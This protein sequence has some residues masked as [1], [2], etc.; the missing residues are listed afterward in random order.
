MKKALTL[1]LIVFICSTTS[2]EKNQFVERVSSFWVKNNSSGNIS[3]SYS[4]LYPDT[5]IAHIPRYKVTRVSSSEQVPIDSKKDWEKVI[6]EDIPGRKL[7]VFVFEIVDDNN[8]DS[9]KTNYLVKKRFDLSVDDLK[10]INWT[11]AYP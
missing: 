3:I 8:W 9:V 4:L 6:N 5:A 1:L 2:C 7:Q 10:A 11:I